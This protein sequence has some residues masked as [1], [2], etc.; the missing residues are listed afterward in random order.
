MRTHQELD[1]RSL[2]LH[3]LIADKIRRNPALFGKVR[4]TLVR[5]QG[6]VCQSAQPYLDEWDCLMKA[7]MAACLAVAEED[8]VRAAALRQSSP[9][10]GVLTNVERLSFLKSWPTGASGE[11]IQEARKRLIAE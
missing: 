6:T 8:S 11:E 4:E 2:A 1:E 9:F 5:W 10:C 3:R 7:G